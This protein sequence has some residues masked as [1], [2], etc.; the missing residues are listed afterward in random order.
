M[1]FHINYFI[2]HILMQFRLYN[3]KGSKRL[4]KSCVWAHH[5]L[6]ENARQ[7]LGSASQSFRRDNRSTLSCRAQHQLCMFVWNDLK[8]IKCLAP[9]ISGNFRLLGTRLKQIYNFNFEKPNRGSS[10][11]PKSLYIII[12]YILRIEVLIVEK[13]GIP[14]STALV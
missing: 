10:Q 1:L 4:T 13:L 6:K 7:S 12:R 11:P 9:E 2:S 14:T 5:T 8:E 3:C